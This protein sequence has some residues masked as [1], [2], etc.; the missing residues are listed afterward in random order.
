MQLFKIRYL[1]LILLCFGLIQ[2]E[3]RLLF[4]GF[5]LNYNIDVSRSTQIPN[6]F[7]GDIQLGYTTPSQQAEITLHFAFDFL[8]GYEKDNCDI[9]T[10]QTFVFPDYTIRREIEHQFKNDKSIKVQLYLS[11]DIYKNQF[12]LRIQPRFYFDFNSYSDSSYSEWS[13]YENDSFKFL[14]TSTQP[15]SDRFDFGFYPGFLI[16]I[17]YKWKK[18]KFLVYNANIFYVG[19]CA[20]YTFDVIK[21]KTRRAKNQKGQE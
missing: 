11:S 19:I 10:E 8:N 2:S 5:G 3:E 7:I 14:G 4:T 21:R 13:K 20:D 12:F 16:G 17:G 18:I 1:L 15:L 9:I 6:E